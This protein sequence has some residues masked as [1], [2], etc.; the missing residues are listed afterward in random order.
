MDRRRSELTNR[1]RMTTIATIDDVIQGNLR[2]TRNLFS[3][4]P[5]LVTESAPFGRRFG[6]GLSRH[7]RIRRA[8]SNPA[9]RKSDSLSSGLVFTDFL[10]LSRRLP[11]STHRSPDLGR[12]SPF[13]FDAQS[14]HRYK[15]PDGSVR[16]PLRCAAKV[17]RR[18]PGRRKRV[19]SFCGHFYN[20]PESSEFLR[21]RCSRVVDVG[22]RR[23]CRRPAGLSW[24]GVSKRSY[25]PV[26][27]R[28]GIF[29]RR[30]AVLRW[31]RR[32]RDFL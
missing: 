13:R 27:T 29:R 11:H 1:K 16:S 3:S 21:R 19:S 28:S 32:H 4:L 17:G 14:G 15:P 6:N 25:R 7:F 31:N 8:F 18:S 2:K 24:A 20:R 26:P 22:H 10:N 12:S 5:F 23:A 9:F 30:A